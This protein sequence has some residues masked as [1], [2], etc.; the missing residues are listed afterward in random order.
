MSQYIMVHSSAQTMRL[1]R[2]GMTF[3]VAWKC[4]MALL[5]PEPGTMG[6][7]ASRIAIS[8]PPRA[9][10][11]I[12]SFRLPRWPI[13]REGQTRRKQ[14]Q[15]V[16]PESG[17]GCGFRVCPGGRS[18]EGWLK[19]VMS[20]GSQQGSCVKQCVQEWCLLVLSTR[21]TRDLNHSSG[22]VHVFRCFR[23]KWTRAHASGACSSLHRIGN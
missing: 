22:K 7:P 16:A 17:P 21:P 14:G 23:T 18:C 3:A 9:A 2:V 1:S 13:L 10:T 12:S 19:P 11:S 4:S 5:T 8:T 6:M 20:R 15:G